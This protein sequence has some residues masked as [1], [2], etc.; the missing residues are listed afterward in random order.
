MAKNI[1]GPHLGQAFKVLRGNL[2]SCPELKYAEK[3][4]HEI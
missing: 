3:S 4:K 2:N 1:N